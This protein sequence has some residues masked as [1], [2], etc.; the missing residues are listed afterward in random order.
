MESYKKNTDPT[1]SESSLPAADN[2][3]RIT[4]TTKIQ[5]VVDIAL[6]KIKEHS[7]IVVIGKGKHINKSITVVEIV[8]RKMNG[9]LHQYNQIGT[10]TST[11]SWSPAPEEDMDSITVD[12]KLPVIIIHLSINEL[13]ELE[14]ISGYQPP[15]NE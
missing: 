14:S 1:A 8:K 15:I 3:I 4:Q 7:H 11:E 5:R 10:V 9:S 2:E 6:N 13:P 12:K